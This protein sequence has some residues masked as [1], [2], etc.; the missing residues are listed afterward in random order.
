MRFFTFAFVAFLLGCPAPAAAIEFYRDTR[1]NLYFEG[2]RPGEFIHMT[3]I[4]SK[5]PS[6]YVWSYKDPKKTCSVHHIFRSNTKLNFFTQIRIYTEPTPIDFDPSPSI[7]APDNSNPCNGASINTA[8]PWVTIAPGVQAVAIAETTRFSF[9]RSKLGCTP[10][11]RIWLTTDSVYVSGLSAPAYKVSDERDRARFG[12]ADACGFMKL[13]NTAKWPA[14]S[15]DRI[16]LVS[17]KFG[18][19][20]GVFSRAGA[21][22]AKTRAVNQIPLCRDGVIYRP[23]P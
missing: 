2:L 22:G 6:K 11:Q 3:Y 10:S 16:D 23:I 7:S 15:T 5:T 18:T 14:R 12:V 1:D 21:R 4:D 13:A 8:L 9:C 17:R 19:D 20:Y